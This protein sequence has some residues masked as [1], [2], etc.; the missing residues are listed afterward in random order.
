GSH[1]PKPHAQEVAYFPGPALVG[2]AFK[3]VMEV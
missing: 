2:A 1:P 3:R